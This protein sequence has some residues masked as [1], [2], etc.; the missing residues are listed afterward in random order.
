MIRLGHSLRLTDRQRSRTVSGSAPTLAPVLTF[1]SDDVYLANIAWTSSNN[2]D[3]GS[4]YRIYVIFNGAPAALVDDVP[5]PTLTY[6]YDGEG[7][8]EG[9]HVLYIVPY[10][11]SG[12]GPPSN[13]LVLELPVVVD[14]LAAF[15]FTLRLQEREQPGSIVPLGMF[16]DTPPTTLATTGGQSI[17]SWQ[18][19]LSGG[20]LYVTQSNIL[21][22]MTLGFRADGGPELVSDNVDDGYDLTLTAG[23][24]YDVFFYTFSGPVRYQRFWLNAAMEVLQRSSLSPALFCIAPEGETF[25]NDAVT[26]MT[27]RGEELS[28]FTVG[29]QDVLRLV[30][31]ST[32]TVT[33]SVAGTSVGAE[34]DYPTGTDAGNSYSRAMTAGDT[35]VLRV[36]NKAAVTQVAFG[37]QELRGSIPSLA[38]FTSLNFFRCSTNQ[39]TGSIP[40]LAGLTS[41]ATFECQNNQLTG[42]IPSLADFTSL[43]FFNCGVN[44]LTGVIPS[45]TGLTALTT[46]QCFT[47]QLTGSIPSLSGLTLLSIFR[48]DANQLTGSIPSLSGLTALTIFRCQDNQLTGFSGSVEINLGDFQATNNLLT[49]FAVDAILAAF[50][51]AGRNSGTRVLNIG[52]TGNAAPS[53]AGI[54]DKNTLISRGWTVTTN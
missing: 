11:S 14:P 27:A 47:N 43:V 12:D 15:A 36:A 13:E 37:S 39:L 10:N 8:G 7:L 52:G 29:A 46:F 22:R 35:L 49:Q 40:S 1:V 50:V 23:E 9:E 44:Q 24:T 21:R 5:H 20:G 31:G 41:L 54:T 19:M 48:C 33:A 25:S 32:R 38:G 26:A 45:L 17:A 4:G 3:G 30:C 42:S 34:W 28:G 51:A 6:E 53:A 16:T 2:I 18:D